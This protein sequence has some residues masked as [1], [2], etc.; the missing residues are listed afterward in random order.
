METLLFIIRLAIQLQTPHNLDDRHPNT[1]D[2]PPE[3]TFDFEAMIQANAFYK[4]A[5]ILYKS[6]FYLDAIDLYVKG[7]I[8]SPDPSALFSIAT[9]YKNLGKTTDAI[10]Y[11]KLYLSS[12]PETDKRRKAAERAIISLTSNSP[13]DD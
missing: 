11:Y 8:I 3:E 2:L 10:S 13:F 4:A 6:E 12:T 5:T 9:C 7:S 1:F